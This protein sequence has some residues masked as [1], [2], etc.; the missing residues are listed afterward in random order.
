MYCVLMRVA[1]G[2]EARRGGEEV[3]EGADVDCRVKYRDRERSGRRRGGGSDGGDGCSGDGR[4]NVLKGDILERDVV[5]QVTCELKVAP[6]VLGEWGKEGVE[7]GLGEVDDVGSGFFSELFEVE[8][9]GGAKCL[10]SGLGSR[11]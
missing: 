7:L 11:W 10:L 1:V 8:L 3:F 9:G 4:G 5:D 6:T 2:R